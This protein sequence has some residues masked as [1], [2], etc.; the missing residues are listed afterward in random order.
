M[1]WALDY[2]EKEPTGSTQRHIIYIY[3]GTN[4]NI[5]VYYRESY[6]E[7]YFRRSWRM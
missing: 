6:D 1:L 4:M 2:R 5:D 3:V 7:D